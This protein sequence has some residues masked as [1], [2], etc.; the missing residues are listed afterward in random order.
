M[1]RFENLFIDELIIRVKD[2][3]CLYR[4]LNM[5]MKY[6]NVDL[7]RKYFPDINNNPHVFYVNIILQIILIIQ[8]MI[9]KIN[10]KR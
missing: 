10:K 9:K 2:I 4:Y 8:L 1:G 3:N 7:I 6:K 5:L